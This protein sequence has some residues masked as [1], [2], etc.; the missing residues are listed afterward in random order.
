MNTADGRDEATAI[1]ELER[2]ILAATS[3]G[4]PLAVLDAGCGDRCA[5]AYPSDADVTGVDVSSEPLARNARLDRRIVADLAQA[6]LGEQ[7]FDVIVCWDVLEHLRDPG[8]A[9]DNMADALAPNGLLVV[10]VPNVRSLKGLATKFTPYGFHRWLYRTFGITAEA[11]PFP[12]P[13]RWSLAAD[14]LRSWGQERGLSLRWE[15]RWEA[16]IQQRLR[17]KV[18]LEGKAWRSARRVGGA[19]TLGSVE[20]RA[21]DFVLVFAA[22]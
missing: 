22:A 10:K 8:S 1:A 2:I 21:T 12:T 9:L 11:M 16:E 4:R 18:G 6:D 5:L 3:K 19:L 7:R 17:A 20:G 13:F 15:A 14:A